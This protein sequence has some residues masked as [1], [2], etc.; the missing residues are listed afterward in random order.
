[1]RIFLS[2]IVVCVALTAIESKAQE[3]ERPKVR[4]SDVVFMYSS[5]TP[6]Q[7]DTYQ[8]TIVGWGGRPG[9]RS[10]ESVR[11]FGE[12]VEDAHKR[13]MKYCASV[14]FL[15]DF[16][17]FIDYR[18]D[19]FMQAVCRDLDGNP[20]RVP[21]LWDHEHKGHPA[22]WFCTNNPDY[23]EYLR[24]QAQRA[25]LASID[26]LHID[27]YSGSSACSAYNGG[28]FCPHCMEGFRKYLGSEV[29]KEELK[30][31]GVED[32][33]TF[34]YAEYLKERGI[35]A[36]QYKNEHW[37]VPLIEQFQR[38]QNIE[39]KKRILDIYRTAETKE[40]KMLLRSINSSA[41]SP[42]TLVPSPCID[43]F[44]GEVPHD[45]SSLAGPLHPVFVYKTVEALN[46]RQTAT[47]SG[48]DWA[49]IKANEKPGLVRTWI[50]QT[51]AFGSVFMVPHRQ[52]CYTQE[53]GT[54]WWNGKPEDFAYV[55]RFVRAK[56]HLLDGYRSLADTAV[57]YSMSDY[58]G[59]GEAVV[60]LTRS[61]IPFAILIEGNDELPERITGDQA[62]QYE[63]L[64]ITEDGTRA[65]LNA[66]VGE[67]DT[68][69]VQWQG[70]ST[71]PISLKEK[72]TI[73]GADR[74][75]VSIRHR[76][77]SPDSPIVCHVLNLQYEEDADKVRPADVE[78]SISEDLLRLHEGYKIPE[79]A[80]LHEPNR[81][82]Q[83][84]PVINK[85]GRVTLQI[86]EMGFWGIVEL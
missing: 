30:K 86:R 42:R 85:G 24:D 79:I 48:H 10:E 16:A 60:E 8:G 21:W 74:L 70:L 28:C 2:L 18:P 73:Q 1:M 50:A 55:Y 77:S 25:C 78:V 36:A 11:R 51:Y 58:R 20:L 44:C 64:L 67:S 53:L 83:E 13:N 82:S 27:D 37:K 54:H 46:R 61:N 19:S 35:T 17:G 84:L 9:S 52:W 39:M 59:A 29:S 43:Y 65:E 15:V 34:D 32:I 23:Q 57:V 76:P 81:Q 47:A 41:S 56:S 3:A 66:R 62:G 12:R 7:Y 63:R 49:W 31:K 75:R 71:L 80:I 26:G 6:S 4:A 33:E 45:A 22:Y 14:D 5:H 40:G 69:I 38:Y 68:E 72:I